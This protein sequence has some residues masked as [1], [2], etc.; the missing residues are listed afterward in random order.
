MKRLT[1][2][3][4]KDII[5]LYNQGINDFKIAE[6]LNLKRAT[7]QYFRKAHNLPTKFTYKQFEKIQK[8]DFEEYYYQNLTDEEI[9]QKLNVTSDGIYA[10]RMRNHYIRNIFEVRN[11]LPITEEVLSIL[12]GT[13]L[14]DASLRKRDANTHAS[15][16]CAHGIKQKEYA[17]F[18]CNLLKPLNPKISKHVR[19]K[20]DSRT[21]IY[22]TDYTIHTK[23]NKN[24][25]MLYNAFYPKGKKVIPISL[26]KHFTAQSLALMF[27]DDGSKDSKGGYNIAT[28][29]FERDNI[30]EFRCFLF[31]NFNIETTVHKGNRL[32]IKMN[33]KNL[34]KTLVLPYMCKSMMYKL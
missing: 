2:Q 1:E 29:C 4:K 21:G 32:Y 15:F 9:A 12:I 20:V 14:G 24:L 6:R 22:Y 28:N 8:E 33:S 10:Y 19:T 27:M 17:E 7:V 5:D 13:L 11:S 30:D 3:N 25:D 34:F 16:S 23:T 18:K 26:L 31:A